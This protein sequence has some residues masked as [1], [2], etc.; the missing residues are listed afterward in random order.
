MIAE[1][2]TL[3]ASYSCATADDIDYII[4]RADA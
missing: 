3:F 4:L 2:L 1:L